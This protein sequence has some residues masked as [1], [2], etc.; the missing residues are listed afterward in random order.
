MA[1]FGIEFVPNETVPT[2]INY[3]KFAED[4]GLNYLWITDHYNNR[5]VFEMLALIAANTSRI[6][7][8]PGI[9]NAFTQSPAVTASAICTI[10]EIS[11]GRATLGIGPG[12]LSTLPKIGIPMETPV[13]RLTEAVDIIKGL[14]GW[15]AS[16]HP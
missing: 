8:G 4:N 5:N 16:Q 1:T 11:N 3:C 6:K 15:H 13:A 10:D 7:M 14:S 12:D 9:T 2:I